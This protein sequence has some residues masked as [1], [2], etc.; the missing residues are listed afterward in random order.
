MIRNIKIKLFERKARRLSM[1]S[2]YH[3]YQAG[4]HLSAANS[5]E[6]AALKAKTEA[7][8]LCAK[9]NLELDFFV[10]GMEIRARSRH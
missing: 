3:R 9:A 7:R 6:Q 10:C 8:L 5:F 4:H 1:M 2:D